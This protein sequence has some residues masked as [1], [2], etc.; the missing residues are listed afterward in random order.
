MKAQRTTNAEIGA[1]LAAVERSLGS[2]ESLTKRA[3]K[4]LDNRSVRVP[5]P[6]IEQL[7]AIVDREGSVCGMSLDAGEIRAVLAD[8]NDALAA[9]ATARLIA[10]R[11]VDDAV[12]KRVVVADTAF[13]IYRALSRLTQTP[14]GNALLGPYKEMRAVV[15]DQRTPKRPRKSTKAR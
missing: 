6:L 7:L 8:V 13:A 4:A 3:R 2:V 15:R 11:L 12:S 10:Q 9:A 5:T 14:E 1:Q